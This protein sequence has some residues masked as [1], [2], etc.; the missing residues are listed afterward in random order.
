MP[1]VGRDTLHPTLPGQFRHYSTHTF[2]CMP[3]SR[4]NINLVCAQ[5]GMPM[6][7]HDLPYL[8]EHPDRHGK[9]RTA[10]SR[11]E[12]TKAKNPGGHA[13]EISWNR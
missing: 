11:G 2:R 7:P 3:A 13:N 4:K 5:L 12:T 10:A 1:A 9:G 6:V 8:S